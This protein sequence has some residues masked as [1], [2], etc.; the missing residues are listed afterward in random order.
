MENEDTEES[1]ETK[2]DCR[3]DGQAFRRGLDYWI[4]GGGAH[5]KDGREGAWQGDA[6]ELGR[7]DTLGKP[8][9]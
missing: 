7:S 4:W 6:G 2:G 8:G 5:T 1:A 9:D 3:L